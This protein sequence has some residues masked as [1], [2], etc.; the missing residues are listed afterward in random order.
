MSSADPHPSRILP[1]SRTPRQGGALRWRRGVAA[2]EFALTAPVVAL[3]MLGTVDLMLFMRAQVKV[4]GTAVQIG[5][6]VSQC[7]RISTADVPDFWRLGTTLLSGVGE[8]TSSS[9]AAVIITA[10]R[11]NNSANT[12]AWQ[13]KSKS[14]A[15]SAIGGSSGAATIPAGY[16]VPAGQLLI[17]TEVAAPVRQFVLSQTL[18]AAGVLPQTLQAT[19]LYLSRTPDPTTVTSA[20][21]TQDQ[22]L[23]MA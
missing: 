13:Q 19:T 9:S 5:Q 4:E 2:S 18:V 16:T 7:G 11:N 12:V 21:V 23:C 8:V 15:T 22:K 10:V 17:V 3:L 1:G 14:S 20:P 6:I